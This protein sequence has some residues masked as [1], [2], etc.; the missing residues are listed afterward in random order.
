MSNWLHRDILYN[1][2]I[3]YKFNK[4]FNN[5]FGTNEMWAV[6]LKKMAMQAGQNISAFVQLEIVDDATLSKRNVLAHR[7][8]Y[9]DLFFI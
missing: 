8:G 1:L 3:Q 5:I 4:I 6:A 9:L 2:T 7:S